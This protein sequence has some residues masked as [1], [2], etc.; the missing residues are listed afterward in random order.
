MEFI[1]VKADPVLKSLGIHDDEYLY[2]YVTICDDLNA[3]IRGG[4]EL[5]YLRIVRALVKDDLFFLCYF[6]LELP[7]NHPF[8]LARIKDVQK[9]NTMTIDL[10]A[11]EHWKSTILSCALPIFELI[12]NPNERIAI[13]SHTRAMA[14]SHM[15][16]I[17]TILENNQVL[18]KAFPEIFYQKPT[19]QAPK[20]SE[21]EGIYVKRRNEFNEASVEAWGIIENM[22]TGKHFSILVYDDLVDMNA[23][24]T[25][26]QIE[27]VNE[28]FKMSLN[29]GARH[30][31]RRIIGTRYSLKDPYAEI[32]KNHRYTIR[33]Y[34]AEVDEEGKKKKGGFPVFL[35]RE[36]LDEKLLAFGEY[37]YSSQMLQHPVAESLQ[38]FQR[39]WL[40]FYRK[41]PYMYYYIVVDAASKKRKKSDYTVIAVIGT[42]SLRNYYLVDMVRDKL[43]LGERWEKLKQKVLEWGVS[44][45]GYEEYAAMSDIEY[46]EQMMRNRKVIDL[47]R[48]TMVK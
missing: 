15:R 47:L 12:H 19:S 36:E 13:I 5:E 20:W 26:D 44:V 40:R 1:P 27:K 39:G 35:G 24:S 25:S 4:N 8:L 22:P 30:G 23:V 31:K 9:L 3:L 17:K 42:D 48:K 18:L 37:V 41:T 14:K 16:R 29:L 38:Q 45:V 46:M 11:R 33:T 10:W 21:D 43:N 6:V 32:M 28:R 7:V 34:P 2:D